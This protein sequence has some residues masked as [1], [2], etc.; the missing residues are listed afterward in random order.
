MGVPTHCD[1]SQDDEDGIKAV[2]GQGK[3]VHN[4]PNGC[5]NQKWQ[6]EHLVVLQNYEV[7]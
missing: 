2:N 6:E 7:L 1:D 3:N 5:E 4:Y